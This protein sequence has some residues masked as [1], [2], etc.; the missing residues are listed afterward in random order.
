MHNENVFEIGSEK[1]G[2]SIGERLLLARRRRKLDQADMA[3][4]ARVSVNSYAAYEHD[5]RMPSSRSLVSLWKA[6][7]DTHWILTGSTKPRYDVEPTPE[8]P[9]SKVVIDL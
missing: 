9:Q 8:A 3:A 4:L 1:N 5:D 7:I 2:A 6:G